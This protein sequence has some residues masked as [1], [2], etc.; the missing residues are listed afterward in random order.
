VSDAGLLAHGCEV[1]G[2]E[3]VG[4]WAD[5]RQDS[6][7]LVVWGHGGGSGRIGPHAEFVL[8]FGD[9]GADVFRVNGGIGVWQIGADDLL[10]DLGGECL[11]GCGG[12]EEA[13]EVVTTWGCCWYGGGGGVLL[14][15][16]LFPTLKIFLALRALAR[17]F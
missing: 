17:S 13:V 8:E 10:L 7:G 11:G 1:V 12:L 3:V 9:D 2:G 5:W 14:A 4:L 15:C 16:F 6:L